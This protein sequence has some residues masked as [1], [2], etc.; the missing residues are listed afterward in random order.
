MRIHLKILI[1]LLPVILSSCSGKDPE[2]NKNKLIPQKELV[3]VITDLYL[4]DGLLSSPTIRNL[5]T[6]K[7]SI[8]NYIDIVNKHGYTKARMDMT[9]KYYFIEN[10]KKLQEIYDQVLAKL[11]EMQSSLETISLE[12]EGENLWNQKDKLSVPEDGSHNLLYFSIPVKDTG[13]YELAFTAIIYNDDRSNYPRTATFFWHTSDTQEG[14]RNPWDNI[15]LI[16][17]GT[18]H[19]Y[20]IRRKLTDTTFTH[21]CGWLFQCDDQP[22]LWIKHGSFSSISLTKIHRNIE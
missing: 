4:A 16:R 3:S 10:P 1:T 12:P 15:D 13:W 6:A 2:Y 7:D 9:M 21:I 19:S 18:R 11:S 8:A 22:G 20:S 17:D 14:V 5:F